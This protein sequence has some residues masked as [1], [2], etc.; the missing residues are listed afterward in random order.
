MKCIFKIYKLPPL[1]F[2]LC[3]SFLSQLH[4]M[5]VYA[6]PSYKYVMFWNGTFCCSLQTTFSFRCSINWTIKIIRDVTCLKN[7]LKS[8]KKKMVCFFLKSLKDRKNIF[9]VFFSFY[10]FSLFFRSFFFRASFLLSCLFFFHFP[11]LYFYFYFI[12]FFISSLFF[13]ISFIFSL[14]FFLVFFSSF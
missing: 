9:Q 2:V 12:Y 4:V 5:C 7:Y 1:E 10:T 13:Y 6:K 14:L 3:Y 8:I 11:D